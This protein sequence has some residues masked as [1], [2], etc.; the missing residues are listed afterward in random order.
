MKGGANS[1]HSGGA[2]EAKYSPNPGNC[3]EPSFGIGNH[4]P[5]PGYV[6]K[7]S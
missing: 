2:T 7:T 6:H 1:A 5:T 3:T 4:S